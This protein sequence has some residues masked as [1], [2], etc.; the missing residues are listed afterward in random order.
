LIDA[1]TNRDFS[2]LLLLAAVA[3]KLEWFLWLL[4]GGVNLFWPIVLGLAWKA[5]RAAHG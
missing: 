4:A 1:L 5:R 3:G 2:I